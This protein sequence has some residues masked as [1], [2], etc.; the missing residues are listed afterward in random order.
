M[1]SEV[2]LPLQTLQLNKK[3]GDAEFNVNGLT[4]DQ[5]YSLELNGSITNLMDVINGEKNIQS[6]TNAN[7]KTKR[8]S[9]EDFI[10]ILGEGFF[11]GSN[12]TPYEKRRDMKKTLRGIQD[13]FQPNIYFE[14][15]SSGYYD[16]VSMKNIVARMHFPE[17]DVLAIDSASFDLDNG[18]FDFNGK[19]DISSDRMT[20]FEI[21]CNAV[22]INL[23]KLL[24][25]ID[26]LGVDALRKLGFLPEDF[27][28]KIRLSGVINDFTGIV[29]N[30]LEGDI[31]FNST[32]RRVEFAHIN[33]DRVD[34][35]DSIENKI[36]SD[37]VTTM[38]IK[39]NPLVFNSYLNNDQFFFNE[40]DFE[41]DVKYTGESVSLDNII[42]DGELTLSIDSSFVFYEPLSVTFPL[43]HIDLAVKNN[44]AQYSILMK[45]DTLN[46]QV[47]LDGI[48]QNFSQIIV[49]DTGLPVSTTSNIYSPRFTWENFIDIFNIGP[50][51]LVVPTDTLSTL[52]K[53]ATS[54]FCD[55]LYE[56]SPDI[57]MS[58]DTLEYSN[59]LSIYNF[60]S[61][62][63]LED[64]VFYVS[65]AKFDYRDSEILMNSAF[66]L[67]DDIDSIDAKFKAMN[68]DIESTISDAEELTK[69]DYALFDYMS[70]AIDL[71][72]NIS[73]YYNRD[74]LLRDTIVNGDV[75]FTINDLIIEDAPWMEKIGKKLWHPKRFKKLK[76][77]PITNQLTFINDSI[78]VPLMEL[79]SNA[80]NIF[81]DG[82]YH[83]DY[84]NIWLS[85]PLFNLKK[86]DLS[87]VPI[88]E[89]YARRKTKF[90]LEYGQHKKP[91][92]SFKFRLSKRKFYKDRG[93]LDKWKNRR[94]IKN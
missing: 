1:P 14:I 58:F 37:L 63:L 93:L 46:Q 29:S 73:Q 84:P 4:A 92:P 8:L 75:N 80:F 65:N 21:Y 20:P 76:F 89:G 22:D 81:I 86:R 61:G 38:Q 30:S 42:S 2:V 68:I 43:T 11:D 45:S 56:F 5:A 72:V 16:H 13:H 40:G 91:K 6:I 7:L 31:V 28:I 44:D 12:K 33:F 35:L 69:K 88:K 3:S 83:D 36:V 23:S 87:I 60:S 32:K 54:K 27:D 50:S 18:Y 62:L 34:R 52:T 41:L 53:T 70:G 26:F 74:S 57:K 78:Y 55:L 67:S 25:S 15:D 85:I 82:Y 48:V 71:E 77:A 51:E 10:H 17:K 79:Q 47:K 49:E 90:H 24:P 66:Y 64:S 39:G 59:D 9:W 19:Y 94:K